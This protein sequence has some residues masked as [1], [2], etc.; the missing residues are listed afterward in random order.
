MSA[1]VQ[2]A[3]P[4]PADVGGPFVS[5]QLAVLARFFAWATAQ[6]VLPTVEQAVARFALR[7]AVAEQWLD[8]LAEAYGVDRAE[9]SPSPTEGQNR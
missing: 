9:Q 1:D 7:R 5:V 8:A 6:D 3:A 2:V 4:A